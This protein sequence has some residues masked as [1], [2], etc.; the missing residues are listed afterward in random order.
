MLRGELAKVR[1]QSQRALPD[2]TA[3]SRGLAAVRSQLVGIASVYGAMR[4]G[5]AYV[6]L[7]DEASS[8][9]GR[10]R[11]ATK[12]QEEFNR[13]QQQTFQIAQETSAEWSSIVGLYAQ[14]S[15]TT[16][17]AQDRILAL[18]KTI[19]QAFTVSGASAQETANGLRQL[20]QAMAGG[21]LRAEEFNTIIETSPRIVQALADHFGISFGQVRK[22][23]NDGKITSEEFA[24]AL[25]KAA[26]SV[27]KDFRTMPLTVA[28]AT[29]QVRNALLKLVGDTD[30]AGG[31]SKELAE[32]IADMARV[33]ESEDTKRGFGELVNGLAA[34]IEGTTAAAAAVG[35]LSTEVKRLSGVSLPKWAQASLMALSGNIPGAVNAYAS[36][37][38]QRPDF[39]NVVT[40]GGT[41]AG[42]GGGSGGGGGDTAKAIAA[43]NALLRDSVARAMAELD[44]LYKGHEVGIREYFAARQQMQERAIDLQV[45]QARAELAITKDAGKRRDLE[46]QI[47]ILMRDRAEVGAQAAREQ[48]AAEDDLIDKLGELKAQI[49]EL[50]GDHV[51]AA[52]IRIEAEFL[53]LFQRLRAESD[54]AGEAMARNLVERLVRK[55]QTD[56]IRARAGDITGRL[57]SEE[58]SVSAQVDAG[59]L[60]YVEGEERLREA[61]MLA[62]QQLGE[63][64]R[65]Q[66][67]AMTMM[68]PGSPEHAAALQGL[69][70]LEA[71]YANIAASVDVFRNQ[72]KDVATDAL[73]GLFMDL[74]EGTKSA[75]D[76]LRDFVRSFALSMAQIAARALATYLVLQLL[77]AVYPGL[78][79]ATAAMMGAGQNHAG[80][81]AGQ[82]GGVRRWIPE[83]MLGVAPRYHNGG[84]AGAP[85]LKHNEV[86]SVLERGE[87]IRTQQQERA[88]Q[89]QLDA[90]SGK[91]TVKQPIVAIG[92]RAVADAMAGAAGEDIVITHVRNNWGSLSAS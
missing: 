58:G 66:R 17:M 44:R 54:D 70:E 50:D 6:R 83:A 71:G 11:L 79:K 37:R 2:N 16:G 92:D 23:V 4:A 77:D 9:A 25:E 45:E 13:A 43:S 68:E 27:D 1:T 75:G 48:T 76:A 18:T 51:R 73:T 90:G 56:A 39:S 86:V 87:T 53:E 5:G 41:V 3:W 28:K 15:Q 65:L 8:L 62:L 67:E 81:T 74:V 89:G 20:Q 7:A 21:V 12:S 91:V 46:E 35:K 60:G 55:A 72:V 29:Q 88:L 19:S 69:H 63:Q 84:I 36:G 30:Q 47:A 32:A 14:L 24:K 80:G 34:I 40:G 85:P 64:I 61:R 82:V 78:G 59:M 52:R 42:G 26:E 10:L 33:L 49:A 31:A 22:Y 57:Q 38:N